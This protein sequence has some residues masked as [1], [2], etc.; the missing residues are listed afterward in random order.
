MGT[1]ETLVPGATIR[2]VSARASDREWQRLV[3][4]SELCIIIP[5]HMNHKAMAIV[6]VVHGREY[7]NAAN[8]NH[9]IR[10]ANE[11][12]ARGGG[13]VSGDDNSWWTGGPS[14]S[15]RDNEN[16]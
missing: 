6:R 7:V 9:A 16:D 11:F 2:A 5:R 3:V 10:I 8:F 15:K 13:G 4:P 14:T 1:V 12:V